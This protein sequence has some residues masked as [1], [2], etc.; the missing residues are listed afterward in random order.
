MVSIQES[1][2]DQNCQLNSQKPE[3]RSNFKMPSVVMT[4]IKLILVT[5]K[6]NLSYSKKYAESTEFYIGVFSL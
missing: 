4:D 1:M 6:I 2:P 3:N 5:S